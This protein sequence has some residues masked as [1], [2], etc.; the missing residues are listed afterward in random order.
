MNRTSRANKK[1]CDV[2]LKYSPAIWVAC[3]CAAFAGPIPAAEKTTAAT[4]PQAVWERLAQ[5]EKVQLVVVLNDSAIN[6]E[7]AGKRPPEGGVLDEKHEAALQR[8]RQKKLA[9]LK[10]QVLSRLPARQVD[11]LES[12]DALP[13]M[14]LQFHTARSLK[15]LLAQKII[16]NVYEDQKVN[17][18]K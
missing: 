1:G 18:A 9:A 10:K 15:A 6:A 11:V 7:V 14:F 8:M 3:L 17:L 5:G 16:I 4:A 13:M 2:T 12:Y